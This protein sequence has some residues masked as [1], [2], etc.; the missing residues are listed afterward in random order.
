MS[1]LEFCISREEWDAAD[2][3]GKEALNQQAVEAYWNAFEVVHQNSNWGPVE[4]DGVFGIGAIK[5]PNT[6]KGSEF[7]PYGGHSKANRWGTGDLHAGAMAYKRAPKLVGTGDAKYPASSVKKYPFCPTTVMD[8][9]KEGYKS[10]VKQLAALG[11]S[12]A[13]K[14]GLGGTTA[15]D[16]AKAAEGPDEAAEI[17]AKMAAEKAKKEAEE[18][19]LARSVIGEYKDVEYKEQCFLLA[20]IFEIIQYKNLNLEPTTIK[21]LPYNAGEGNS[22]LMVQSDPYAFMNKMTQYPTQQHLLEARSHEI[23]NLQP[24]I[25]LYKVSKNANGEEFSQEFN[26]DSHATQNDLASMLT[27]AGKRGFGAGIKEFSFTYEGNN[28][29]AVKKSISAKLSIFANT[30][31]ELLKDRGGY[32]YADLALK[33]GGAKAREALEKLNPQDADVKLDN[34]SKLDFRLKAVV[35]WAQPPNPLF[36]N[37]EI[38]DAINNSFVTLNLTPTVHEFNFDEQGRV[39]FTCNYLAYVEDFFDQPAFNVFSERVVEKNIL[40]RKLQ[41]KAYNEVCD[42]E[43]MSNYKK[44]LAPEVKSDKNKSLRSIFTLLSKY[45]RLNYIN[46]PYA[47]L[48]NFKE[49]GP[50]FNLEEA[51]GF[52]IGKVTEG[53]RVGLA[54]AIVEATSDPAQEQAKDEGFFSSAWDTIKS[55]A[56]DSSEE[57]KRTEKEKM[58][59]KIT[60]DAQTEQIVFFYL[61][62]LIDVILKGMEDKLSSYEAIMAEATAELDAVPAELVEKEKEKSQR[63]YENFK[64]FR[65]LL[66]PVEIVNPAN[67]AKS[68]MVNFGDIPISLRYFL[69]WLG[70]KTI[71]RDEATYPLP[72]F[73]NDLMNNL[74][75]DF[76]NNDSCFGYSVKQKTRLNQASVTA[77][78]DGGYEGTGLD[79][80]AGKIGELRMESEKNTISRLYTDVLK[81]DSFPILNISGIRD[82]PRATKDHQ[83]EFNFLIYFAARTQPVER[84]NGNYQEDVSNGILHYMLGK[85]RGIIKNIQLQKTESPGLKEVR[86]EQEGFDGLNQLREVYDVTIDTYANVNAFPGVYIFVDPR[87]FVPNMSYE[88][89]EEGFNIEDL[90]DY[91]LGGYYMIIR[92]EHTFGPGKANTR[93][94][95]KWVNEIHKELD[96]R[97]KRAV[98]AGKAPKDTP[99]K[100]GIITQERK[101]GESSWFSNLMGSELTPTEPKDTVSKPDPESI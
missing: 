12:N 19:A 9:A 52:E 15:K 48:L 94:T 27:T 66:G 60:K 76:L 22:C 42:A 40:K 23:S 37:P 17:A 54:K 59:S 87:G 88:V 13:D 64:K 36:S 84:M 2:G 81:K 53:G 93:I 34:L 16:I 44:Q 31:D 26:F 73:L 57:D 71:K 98:K 61:A 89:K 65:V 11:A 99:K 29:F 46:L 82:D 90:S 14:I 24:K 92:S 96:K 1:N 70:E 62:D 10:F 43:K 35:G 69:D 20:K 6:F 5:K 8:T 33:T 49:Q 91:G 55:L 51:T 85:D 45:D 50:Y 63:Y 74:V 7:D 77:Y 95:A 25:R 32:M 101:Q 72:K 4:T 75:R 41:Y 56:S 86:F 39:T 68:A 47:H 79:P 58:I 80:V 21:P 18:E 100:C 78:S 38:S 28:P 3:A 83:D 67:P 97:D 30:F